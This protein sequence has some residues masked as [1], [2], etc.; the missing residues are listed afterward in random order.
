MWSGDLKASLRIAAK[1]LINKTYLI[2]C[3]LSWLAAF[4]I[5]FKS[6]AIKNLCVDNYISG[7]SWEMATHNDFG[8]CE[9]RFVALW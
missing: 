5:G 6:G 2:Y 9:I 3:T 7:F 4:A 1:T 8:L